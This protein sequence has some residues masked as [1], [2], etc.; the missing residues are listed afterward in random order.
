MFLKYASAHT[1]SVSSWPRK[2]LLANVLNIILAVPYSANDMGLN[3][4]L[5]PYLEIKLAVLCNAN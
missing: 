2:M 5:L 4:L 1:V 3:V